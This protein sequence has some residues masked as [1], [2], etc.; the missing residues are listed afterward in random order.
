MANHQFKVG[1]KVIAEGK[2]GTIF[3]L[4]HAAEQGRNFTTC[5]S[6][7]EISNANLIG[8][9][10]NFGGKIKIVKETDIKLA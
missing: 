2:T 7:K 8:Y 3:T 4:G 1:D 9:Q 6:T 5:D 10:V